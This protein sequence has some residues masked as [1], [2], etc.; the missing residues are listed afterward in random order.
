[1]KRLN[2]IIAG[3]L[4]ATFSRGA[5]SLRP[6]ELAYA[7]RYGADT[8]ICFKVVDD[9]TNSVADATINAHFTLNNQKGKNIVGVTDKDGCVTLQRKSVGEV[10]YSVTKE[11][12]YDTCGRIWLAGKVGALGK[13]EDGKWQPYGKEEKV[14]LKPI[15]NPMSDIAYVFSKEFKQWD[16]CIGFDLE[17]GDFVSPHGKGLIVDFLI[18]YRKINDEGICSLSFPNAADGAYLMEKDKGSAFPFV[19]CADTNSIYKQEFVFNTGKR[20]VAIPKDQ[21]LVVRTRTKI[22]KKGELEEAYY[23]E[24]DG[25]FQINPLGILFKYYRNHAVNSMNLEFS[26]KRIWHERPTSK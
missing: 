19:Y 18:T 3:V 11:G 1:M 2:L 13:V 23:S 15:R 9:Q 26:T 24:I 5:E 7:M 21:Y 6:K 10:V 22:N 8:K 25:D 4:L 14:L 16:Q 12:Y 17:E 20:S